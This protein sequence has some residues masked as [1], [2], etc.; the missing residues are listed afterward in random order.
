MGFILGMHGMVEDSLK[1]WEAKSVDFDTY[2][3]LDIQLVPFAGVAETVSFLQTQ[4][5]TEAKKALEYVLACLK[6]GDFDNLE[7]YYNE[8]PLWI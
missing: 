1:V 4:R 5:G 3:G 6:A 7:A 2:C 8:T